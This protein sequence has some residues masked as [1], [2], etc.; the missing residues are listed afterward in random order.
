[1]KTLLALVLSLSAFSTNSHAA[2]KGLICSSPSFGTSLSM[3]FEGSRYM[4]MIHIPLNHEE[5]QHLMLRADQA[6]TTTEENLQVNV[7]VGSCQRG[8]GDVL[9][10]CKVKHQGFGYVSYRKRIADEEGFAQNVTLSKSLSLPKF[11]LRVVK[12]GNKVMLE[13]DANLVMDGDV[14]DTLHLNKKLGTLND[15][16]NFSCRFE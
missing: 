16:T 5:I 9:A 8:N 11:D 15:W 14:K 2:M 6:A 7:H 13:L 1:M 3:I 4:D 12:K 10:E